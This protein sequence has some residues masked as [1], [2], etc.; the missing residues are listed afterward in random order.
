MQAWLTWARRILLRTDT[1]KE[2]KPF[3]ERRLGV[4][5]ILLVDDT[6][7]RLPNVQWDL[8][9]TNLPI[10]TRACKDVYSIS[11][12]LFLLMILSHLWYA[13]EDPLSLYF[14]NR[15]LLLV[16]TILLICV[17]HIN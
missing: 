2:K 8:I 11:P 17:S 6:S 14:S 12:K 4:W 1:Q 5:R 10:L 16:R 13:I 3:L 7:F 15:L 9:S